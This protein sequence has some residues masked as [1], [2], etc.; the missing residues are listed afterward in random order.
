MSV[1]RL[2]YSIFFI[3]FAILFLE[4]ISGRLLKKLFFLQA[5]QDDQTLFKPIF[6]YR[7]KELLRLI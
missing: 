7:H 3:A 2:V 1:R 4:S 6:G 5:N